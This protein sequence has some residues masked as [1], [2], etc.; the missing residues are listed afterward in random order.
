MKNLKISTRLSGAF[1]L[2]VLMLVGLAVAA[3]AQLSSMRA[4]TVEISEIWLPSIEVV[5]AI[6]AQTAE[7][8]LVALNHIMNTDDAAMA[9]IDQQLIAGREKM[10]QLRKKYEALINSPEEKKLYDEF[11]SN[12]TKYIA[13]NDTALAHSRKNENDQALAIVQGE[14]AKLFAISKEI[15]DKLVKLNADGAAQS[16]NDADTTYTTARNMLLITAALAI[17]VAIAAA[18]WLIR[19]ITAP[20]ARA[21]EVAD[22][23][24]GGDLTAH[25]DVDSRDETGQLLSALQRMQQSLVRTVSVVRQNSESVAS[26]SAQIAS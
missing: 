11:A 17:A 7:L 22:R 3:M 8:R 18:V 5:N 16:K 2:L 13:A 15:L 26:A 9:K 1:A 6:D 24:A 23:V 12:W 10:V 20:L 19:S 25:I 21:V 14:S 4:A